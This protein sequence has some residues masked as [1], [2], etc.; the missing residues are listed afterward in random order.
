MNYL[1]NTAYNYLIGEYSPKSYLQQL[2]RYHK[3][4]S[5][6]AHKPIFGEKAGSGFDKRRFRGQI[7]ASN[8]GEYFHRGAGKGRIER[9]I[10]KIKWKYLQR[11]LWWNVIS[12][13]KCS[14]SNI[15]W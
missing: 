13:S 5:Y 15:V 1:K 4:T 12:E 9:R 10:G 7:A 8:E 2:C 3:R 6:A 14:A 11:Q